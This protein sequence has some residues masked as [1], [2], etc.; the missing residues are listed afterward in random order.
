M[1]SGIRGEKLR[2]NIFFSD[3]S[4]IELHGQGHSQNRR[5]RT[6]KR[7]DV[8]CTQAPKFDVKVLVAGGFCAGGVSKLHFVPK[9]QTVT[10]TYYQ[11]HILPVYFEAMKSNIFSTKKNIVFQQDGASAHTAKST[12]KVLEEEVRTVWGKGI[13]PGNSPDL[14][15][16]ENLWAILKSSAYEEPYH[17][18]RKSN[19]LVLKKN[20]IRFLWTF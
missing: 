1:A 5:Y 3:E 9:G 17:R 20:G 6:E 4:W 14:N 12:M 19:G 15:P 16:I 8:P 13:W 18:I 10:A 7:E 11:E 2:S